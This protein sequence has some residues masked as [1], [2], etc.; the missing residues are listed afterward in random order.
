MFICL[1][2][3][4]DTFIRRNA[5][6][7]VQ[8]WIFLLYFCY[9][10]YNLHRG[11][12]AMQSKAIQLAIL[13]PLGFNLN[14]CLLVS[15][16]ENI[17]GLWYLA[18]IVKLKAL[19]AKNEEIQ[20]KFECWKTVGLLLSLKRLKNLFKPLLIVPLFL[21]KTFKMMKKG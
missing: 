12:E 5:A 4:L 1:F 10:L 18:L 7:L 9:K 6:N 8:I 2:V 19:I 15:P 13:R 17:Y 3:Y 16:L 11:Y 14:S 20:I 21:I